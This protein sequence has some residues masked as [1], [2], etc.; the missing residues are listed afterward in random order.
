MDVAEALTAPVQNTPYTKAEKAY[1][2][3]KRRE[4]PEC[5]Q[6]R[7]ATM[8]WCHSGYS[9]HV[10][11]G[12]TKSSIYGALRRHDKYLNTYRRFYADDHVKI[13]DDLLSVNYDHSPGFPYT[14]LPSQKR[15]AGQRHQ[16]AEHRPDGVHLVGLIFVYPPTA[17]KLVP[18]PQSRNEREG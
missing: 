5:A 2:A 15:H 3:R 9:Y 17:L 18:K 16:V 11:R 12:R 13:S 10:L 1:I 7:L 14:V 8:I 6:R 4:F